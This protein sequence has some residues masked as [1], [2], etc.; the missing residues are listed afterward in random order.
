MPPPDPVVIELP[1]THSPRAGQIPTSFL[2]IDP[3]NRVTSMNHSEMGQGSHTA[4]AM[5]AADEL[6]AAWEQVRIEQATGNR[7]VRSRRHGDRL[8]R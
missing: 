3:D 6:D 8:R 4:L 2:K 1:M 7:P 5:M